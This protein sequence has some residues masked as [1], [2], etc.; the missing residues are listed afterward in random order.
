MFTQFKELSLQVRLL[1]KTIDITENASLFKPFREGARVGSFDS[2][3]FWPYYVGMWDK[4]Q[5]I[6]SVFL[7]APTARK[8]QYKFRFLPWGQ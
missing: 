1:V 2:A 6:A 7:F 8:Y 4:E 5:L 3:V